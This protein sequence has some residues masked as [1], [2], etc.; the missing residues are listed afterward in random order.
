M[1]K[2]WQAE[3]RAD[4]KIRGLYHLHPEDI[5]PSNFQKMNVGSAI[6]YLSSY[7][8]GALH[9]AIKDNILPV[10][11]ETTAW[12]METIS[13]AF[14]TLT[15]RLRETSITRRNENK[16]L[17]E[18]ENIKKLMQNSVIG[19][20]R[21]KRPIEEKNQPSTSANADMEI[22]DEK[23]KPLNYG[24]VLCLSSLIDIS[25]TLLDV[26]GIDFLLF[27]RFTQDALE[28]CFSRI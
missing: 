14:T 23:W 19:K 3:I 5:S 26:E 25:N 1:T 21:R 8:A 7:T 6:R 16:K 4:K 24:F 28:N 18:L 9:N 27:S 22:V 10:E 17:A 13:S 11:A 15:S 12:F 20:A 2:L